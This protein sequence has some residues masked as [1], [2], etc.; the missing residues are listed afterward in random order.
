VNADQQW[1]TEMLDDPADII[2]NNE[3]YK[4]K[5]ILNNRRVRNKMG[6][7]TGGPENRKHR[8]LKQISQTNISIYMH[9]D[10]LTFLCIFV[11]GLHLVSSCSVLIL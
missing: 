6:V 9:F 11:R 1:T 3:R 2:A 4:R 8:F 5:L 7:K 10:L